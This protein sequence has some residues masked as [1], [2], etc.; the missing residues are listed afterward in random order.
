M[1]KCVNCKKL[2]YHHKAVTHNCPIGNVKGYTNYHASMFYMQAPVNGDK[3]RLIRDA[4]TLA[5]YVRDQSKGRSVY[6]TM[7]NAVIEEG[8]KLG[9]IN[10]VD[11]IDLV[12]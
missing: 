11:G 1:S 5:L 7:C 3:K 8:K 10:T 9:L 12:K 4:L 6:T 2:K